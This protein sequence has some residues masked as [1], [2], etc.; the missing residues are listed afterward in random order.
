MLR[1]TQ[2]ASPRR[3][4]YEAI[5]KNSKKKI[6]PDHINIEKYSAQNKKS[7]ESG[8]FLTRRRAD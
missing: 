4:H 3:L 6:E 1:F 2:A 8:I 5:I 7:R